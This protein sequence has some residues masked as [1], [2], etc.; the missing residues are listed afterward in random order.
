MSGF[1][2]LSYPPGFASGTWSSRPAAAT[3][4]YYFATDLG[5]YGALLHSNGA[6]WT[7]VGGS[8]VLYQSGAPTATTSSASETNLAVVTIPAGLLTTKGRLDF[9]GLLVATGTTNTKIG[10]FRVSSVSGDTS[11]GTVVGGWTLTAPQLGGVFSR[12]IWANN[13]TS[14]QVT[15]PSALLGPGATNGS[16]VVSAID[17]TAAWYFNFNG[18]TT[19]GS[20]SIG[21]AALTVRWIE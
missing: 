3:G 15:G 11:G 6:N 13:S 14:A 19:S 9:D 16:V 12:T 2:G 7:P 1:Q 5:N 18:S 21:Y 20:D 4:G 10:R 8:C 17:T